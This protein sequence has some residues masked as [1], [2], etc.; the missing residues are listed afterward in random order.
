MNPTSNRYVVAIVDHDRAVTKCSFTTSQADTFLWLAQASLS[1]AVR[2]ASLHGERSPELLVGPAIRFRLFDKLA[3]KRL[4][5]ALRRRR[6][7]R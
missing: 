7:H 4:A 3:A 1:D 5:I 6:R 2:F